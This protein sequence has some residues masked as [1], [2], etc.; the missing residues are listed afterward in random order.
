MRQRRRV[1]FGV[2]P[3][4]WRPGGFPAPTSRST[5]A[6][7]DHRQAAF[8]GSGR[9]GLAADSGQHREGQHDERDVPVPAVPGAGLVEVAP[10]WWT[11]TMLLREVSLLWPRPIPPMRR[12]S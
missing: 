3:G 11:P 7:A 6:L 2:W 1:G 9:V 5:A 8:W 4:A 12:S 10:G